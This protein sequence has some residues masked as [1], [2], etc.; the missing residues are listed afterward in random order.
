MKVSRD[1][2]KILDIG[3]A[4]TAEKDY[5]RLLEIILKECMDITSSD[6]GTLYTADEGNLRFKI[7]RNSTMNT[8][9]GG[10]GERIDLP[11]VPLAEENICAYAAIHRTMI[12][13]QDVYHSVEFNFMGPKNY[14]SLTGYHTKSMLVFPLVDHEEKLHGV[15]QLINA[16]DENRNI[17]AYGKEYEYIVYSLASQA[18]VTLANV[19]HLEEMKSMLN[20]MAEAFTTA[21]DER[22]P[23]NANHTKNVAKYAAYFM[24]YINRAY[25]AGETKLS[26]GENEKEQIILAARL[27]D[28]G[29]LTVP[30]GVMNKATRLGNGI[31]DVIERLDKILLLMKIDYLEGLLTKQ[32]WEEEEAFL[33]ESREFI[34]RLNTAPFLE[35]SMR[36]KIEELRKK[37]YVKRNGQAIPYLTEAEK[38][39][40]S[41]QK[42]TLSEE[43]RKIMENHVVTTSKILSMVRFGEGY[44]KVA[45]LAG[46]HHEFLDGTGYPGHLKGEELSKGVRLLTIMDIFDSLISSDRPYKKP[47]P[48][49]RAISV[50]HE[51]VWEG[52]LDGE[53][54]NLWEGCV[55]ERMTTQMQ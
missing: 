47:M 48:L 28:I 13:I 11:P 30:L 3:I 35:E 27:H 5:N 53:L 8:Y 26:F 52:K 15:I 45:T 43:E 55:M 16:M 37:E 33:R 4:L 54:V 36:Q 18:A 19:R 12:N 9:Q 38:H 49:E 2:K 34:I 10:G 25:L 42:G 22:T 31:K 46:Q 21:I 23:Y 29:K 20:S 40:L 1:L 24:N 50:L 17:I 41:I 6:A 51:M 39:K 14:D 44:D 32:Q 7:M